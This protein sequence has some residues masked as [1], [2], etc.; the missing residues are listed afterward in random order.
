MNILIN[1]IMYSGECKFI[2]VIP[3]EAAV[4]SEM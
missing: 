1:Q 4:G 2:D 3:H